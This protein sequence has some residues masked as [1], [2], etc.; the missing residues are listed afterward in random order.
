VATQLIA[1]QLFVEDADCGVL[2]KNAWHDREAKVDLASAHP[3]LEVD[4]LWH[5]A[6]GDV[7]FG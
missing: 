6:F 4:I 1:A 3:R 5:A 7:E 2:D